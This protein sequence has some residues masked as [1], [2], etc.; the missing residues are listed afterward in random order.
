MGAEEKVEGSEDRRHTQVI[1]QDSISRLIFVSGVCLALA[2]FAMGYLLYG[3][4][5]W[6]NS[7]AQD[8]GKCA[9]P[10]FWVRVYDLKAAILM[11]I[12]AIAAG[13]TVMLAGTATSFISLRQQIKAS[14]V[15]A[16]LKGNLATASPGIFGLLVGGVVVCF[17][18]ANTAS[19]GQYS[20][21]TVDWCTRMSLGAAIDSDKLPDQNAASKEV[22][23]P[24][25]VSSTTTESKNK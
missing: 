5:K 6:I 23:T 18:I 16:T 20:E 21:P 12:L 7:T 15:S 1:S 22:R 8:A 13:A 25:V 19:I 14:A 11:R 10:A 17:A 9:G 3:E 4:L 2:L 24:P